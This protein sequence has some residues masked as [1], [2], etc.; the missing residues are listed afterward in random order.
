MTEKVR[1]EWNVKGFIIIT[2]N[3]VKMKKKNK[4]KFA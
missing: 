1:S 3:R 4:R 2:V